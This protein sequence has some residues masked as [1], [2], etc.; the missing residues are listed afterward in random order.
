MNALSQNT[1]INAS[2]INTLISE[3]S[4]KLNLSGGTITGYIKHN[5]G[6]VL[7]NV[8]DNQW[9]SIKGGTAHDKGAAVTL[10]GQDYNDGVAELIAH[11]DGVGTQKIHIH[12]S[13]GVTTSKI[14][15]DELEIKYN[16]LYFQG[17]QDTFVA[18]NWDTTNGYYYLVMQASTW[19]SCGRVEVYDNES[20]NEAGAVALI[21]GNTRFSVYPNNI[22]RHYGE[23]QANY[24]YIHPQNNDLEGGEMKLA[25]ANSSLQH[26]ICDN[27][28]DQF[29]LIFQSSA[30][31]SVTSIYNFRKDGRIDTPTGSFWIA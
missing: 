20:P 2:D 7:S 8:S 30:D 5:V 9:T 23:L 31:H 12:P 1:T 27:Y 13:N 17:D 11:K 22:A 6:D 19:G 10:Y 25:A 26:I 16:K 24:F 18:R 28:N 14:H 4:G 15:T 29:R 21:A 3:V